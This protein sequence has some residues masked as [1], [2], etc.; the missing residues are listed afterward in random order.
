MHL[1][2]KM[3]D[4]GGCENANRI[5]QRKLARYSRTSED[6][7]SKS[8]LKTVE[9]RSLYEANLY[10]TC[11]ASRPKILRRTGSSVES[12]P[13]T[14]ADEQSSSE[15]PA[16]HHAATP[17]ESLVLH[18]NSEQLAESIPRCHV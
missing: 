14:T 4:I 16:T 18:P 9:G 2:N 3:C 17:R 15:D 10:C 6:K 8:N 12:L 11:D 7:L 13:D 1:E 5:G